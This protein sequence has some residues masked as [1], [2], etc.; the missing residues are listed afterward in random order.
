MKSEKSQ[1]FSDSLRYILVEVPKKGHER[2]VRLCP[3]VGKAEISE[4]KYDRAGVKKFVSSETYQCEYF[5]PKKE[6][7]SAVLSYDLPEGLLNKVREQIKIEI[8][9]DEE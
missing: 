2:S 6:E 8:V 5:D 3:N 9:W 1:K 4:W 7:S